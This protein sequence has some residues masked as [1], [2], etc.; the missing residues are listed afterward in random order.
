MPRDRVL[1]VAV[2]VETGG[3]ERDAVPRGQAKT[4][5][6]QQVA[7]GTNDWTDPVA[8]TRDL[9]MCAICLPPG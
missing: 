7:G 1:S 4:D 3:I 2:Q 5:L 9:S 6:L 8:Y